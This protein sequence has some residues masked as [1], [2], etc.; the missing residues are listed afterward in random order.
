MRTKQSR[1]GPPSAGRRGDSM[2]VLIAFCVGTAFGGFCMLV[3]SLV[4]MVE[5]EKPWDDAPNKG[6]GK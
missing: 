4:F 5:D 1:S 6:G 3:L 2:A